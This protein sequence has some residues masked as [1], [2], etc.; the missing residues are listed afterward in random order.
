MTGSVLRR[1]ITTAGVGR[2]RDRIVRTEVR[3]SPIHGRGLFATRRIARGETI[4]HFDGVV[5]G[6]ADDRLGDP[7]VILLERADA[8]LYP[9][10]VTNELCFLNHSTGPNADWQRR[11][12]FA[13]R[14]IGPDEEITINYW[15]STRDRG[16]PRR[17]LLG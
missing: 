3:A 17:W 5:L 13:L 15:P 11:E 10:Y 7:R 4:G 16:S 1:V 14:A 12:V 8:E 6:E 9:L 2:S